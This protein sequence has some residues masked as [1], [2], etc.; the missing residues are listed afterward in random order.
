MEDKKTAVIE[1]AAASGL[2]LVS[3]NKRNPLITTTYGTSQLVKATLEQ[4]CRKMIIGIG[5]SVTSKAISI[6][7][8]MKMSKSYTT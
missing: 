8:A 4:G 2:T 1:I 7:E 6:D 3:E 5:R